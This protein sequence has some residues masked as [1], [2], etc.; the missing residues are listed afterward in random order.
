[1]LRAVAILV[2]VRRGLEEEERDLLK[3][4]ND[5]GTPNRRPTPV[6]VATKV[7]R[8]PRNQRAAALA[9]VGSGSMRVVGFSTE[10]AESTADVW[11]ALR[12]AID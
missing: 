1:M 11:R 10:L 7:D 12:A 8:L 6:L 5:A 4:L 2:D 3:L 9:R